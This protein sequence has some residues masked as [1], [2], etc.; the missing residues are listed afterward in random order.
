MLMIA[1]LPLSGLFSVDTALAQYT[2][3]FSSTTNGAMTFT[4]NTLGL[5]KAVNANAP[6]TAD[7]MVHLSRPIR[8]CAKRPTHWSRMDVEVQLPIG[9]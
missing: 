9:H 8:H 2:Q 1:M 6:G 7:G 3:R 4:G 5:S